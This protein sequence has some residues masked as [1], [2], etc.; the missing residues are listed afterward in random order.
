MLCDKVI[1]M[2]PPYL[3]MF[4]FLAS[5]YKSLGD[6]NPLVIITQHQIFSIMMYLKYNS[7]VKDTNH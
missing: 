5:K 1:Y 4:W 6:F 2:K 7:S 3:F